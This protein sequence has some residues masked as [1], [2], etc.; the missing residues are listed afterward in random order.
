MENN[1]EKLF[2]VFLSYK[3]ILG[4]DVPSDFKDEFLW[5]NK[6]GLKL[7]K[8]IFRIVHSEM[9]EFTHVTRS[10]AESDSDKYVEIIA[11]NFGVD[12]DDFNE[13]ILKRIKKLKQFHFRSGGL[14]IHF[15]E[16]VEKIKELRFNRIKFW[17]NLLKD[18]TENEDFYLSKLEERKKLP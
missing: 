1:R 17:E 14:T 2:H 11:G 3:N 6:D 13:R 15:D 18:F 4:I 10:E 16:I 8:S 5:T 12:R 7:L 9:S